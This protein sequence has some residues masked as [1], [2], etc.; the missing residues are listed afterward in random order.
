M[1]TRVQFSFGVL[2]IML[3][4][5]G[6][7]LPTGQ[8]SRAAGSI[9]YVDADATGAGDGSSWTDAF[10]GLQPALETAGSGDQIWVAEGI[11]TPT[12]LFDPLDPRSASF[13]MKNGLAIYGG[14][15]GS[16]TGLEQRDWVSHPTILSGDIGTVG[17]ASDNSYHVFYHLEDLALDSSAV[18]D[19]F[20]ITGG[21]ANIITYPHMLGGGMYNA[22]SSP[23]LN[24][25][26]FSANS[27]FYGGGMANKSGS[28]P[29]LTGVT[30]STNVASNLGG[31]M[32]N[33]SSSPT[34]REVTFSSNSAFYGG[35]MYN[36]DSNLALAEVTFSSNSASYGGGMFNSESSPVLTRVT[37]STNSA[38]YTGGGMFNDYESSPSLTEVTFSGNTADLTGGGMLNADGSNPILTEVTFKAN[39]SSLYGGGMYNIGS[40]PVLTEVVFSGN[41]VNA[42]FGGG[43]ANSDDSNPTL[44]GVTFSGNR[45]YSY[46][47]GIYNYYSS[48]TLTNVI[49]WGNIPDQIYGSEALTSITYSDIQ[50][51]YPGVGNIDLDPRFVR[52]PSPGG[53]GVWGTADD[54]YGDLRL[55]LSPASD[56]GNNAAVPSG[57]TTDL[58]GQ[59]RF[60]DVF[61]ILDTGL[62]TPPVVDMGACEAQYNYV[63]IPMMLR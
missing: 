22:R 13:Q 52:P 41:W 37:F 5:L 63:F 18:L 36:Y 8:A 4:V 10:T 34:L 21:K 24:E 30:F 58:L 2:G 17:D 1:S 53:D 15:A 9:I 54:D 19:G 62:G 48:S 43:M 7:V 6:L 35:G 44:I 16:E 57:I 59:P 20:T 49:L 42:G 23:T 29:S 11:Y 56:A 39:Y 55:F 50:G 3:V 25:I 60:V 27:A 26:T 47:G 40:S 14:F 51:G 12:H 45:A 28:N 46:G 38:D 31:G 61:A 33:S 32:E